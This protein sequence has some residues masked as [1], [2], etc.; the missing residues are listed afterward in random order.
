MI[1][2]LSTAFTFMHPVRKS[3]NIRIKAQQRYVLQIL[4]AYLEVQRKTYTKS[5]K[6]FYH[7]FIMRTLPFY[8]KN[9]NKVRKNKKK[10][11]WQNEK[12]FIIK[13]MEKFD[14]KTKNCYK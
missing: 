10:K 4:W 9:K 13:L 7:I 11:Q 1:N 12:Y 3:Y 6:K 14:N 2:I 8:Y 5:K